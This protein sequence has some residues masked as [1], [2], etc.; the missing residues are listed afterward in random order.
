M[1][2]ASQTP[3]H[4]LLPIWSATISVIVTF[5][6]SGGFQVD[7]GWMTTDGVSKRPAKATIIDLIEALWECVPEGSQPPLSEEWLAEINRRSADYDSG[8][9]ETVSWQAIK[10]DAMLRLER[11]TD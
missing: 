10:S 7:H 11:K 6:L 3:K 1:S 9:V 8:K 5:T 4:C 2:F